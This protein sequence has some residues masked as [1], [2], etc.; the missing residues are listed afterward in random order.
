[1]HDIVRLSACVCVSVRVRIHVCVRMRVQMFVYV[2]AIRAC[3][4]CVCMCVYIVML[5]SACTDYIAVICLQFALLSELCLRDDD[6]ACVCV[7]VCVCTGATC[8]LR[9]HAKT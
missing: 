6:N 2:R 5:V 4:A 8:I 7:Y 1:M 3:I 9:G